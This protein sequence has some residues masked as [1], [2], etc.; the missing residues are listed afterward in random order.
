[1]GKD[2][3]EAEKY[4]RRK[5]AAQKKRKIGRAIG[6]TA[7]CGIPCLLTSTLIGSVAVLILI[8]AKPKAYRKEA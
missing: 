1:M 4:Y 6:T 2:E 7:C 8:R 5:N 3:S